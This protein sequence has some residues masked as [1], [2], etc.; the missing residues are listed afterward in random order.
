MEKNINE[1]PKKLLEGRENLEGKVV[2]SY[3]KKID[4]LDDYPLNPKED[5]VLEESRLLYGLLKN[6]VESQI[7]EIDIVTMESYLVNFPNLKRMV[8]EYGGCREIINSAKVVNVNNFESYY[9]ELIK[10]NYLIDLNLTQKEIALDYEKM[11]KM[12]NE[13]MMAYVEYK[14]TNIENGKST[15]LAEVSNL[16]IDE[17]FMKLCEE[18]GTIETISYYDAFPQLNNVLGGIML[19]KLHIFA[20]MSGSGKS[21]FMLN[22]IMSVIK[23]GLKATIISNELSKYEYLMMI[24]C[25]V[26]FDEFKYYKITRQKLQS[27]IK[28]NDEERTMFRKACK[29]INEN[30]KDNLT[31]VILNTTDMEVVYKEM[32]KACKL[33]SKVILYDTL[34]SSGGEKGWVEITDASKKVTMLAQ[35]EN[36]AIYLSFQTAPYTADK[37][38]LHRGLMS[39]GK[40]AIFMASTLCMMRPLRNDEFKGEK[41]YIKPYKIRKNEETGKYEKVSFD[42]DFDGSKYNLIFIDKNRNGEDGKVILVKMIGSYGKF[43]EIGYANVHV[44]M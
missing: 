4:L 15:R 22:I 2:L 28:L 29:Y 5:L 23:Q 13:E 18:E 24:V 11:K 27:Q 17:E 35:K 33:G 41:K 12:S 19:G 31:F 20:G 39:E 9:E 7:V 43:I 8:D 38:Y 14:I 34:K 40:N 3:Y 44:D 26:L 16:Y 21:T 32:K 30:Y 10:Y 6:M 37:Y 42:L 36:V 25:L 1:I